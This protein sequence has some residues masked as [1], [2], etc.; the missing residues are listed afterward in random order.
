MPDA[1]R[2]DFVLLGAGPAGEKGGRARRLDAAA[3]ALAAHLWA[4]GRTNA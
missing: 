2:Y 3:A 1:E 4:K